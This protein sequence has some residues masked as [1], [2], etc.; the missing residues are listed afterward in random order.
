MMGKMPGR[1]NFNQFIFDEDRH[2][3]T[4]EEQELLL[5]DEADPRQ[6]STPYPHTGST[7]AGALP[8]SDLPVFTTIHQIRRDV[9]ENLDDPY[10]LDQLRAPRMNTTVVRPM[11]DNLYDMLDISVV[12]CLLVNRVQFLREQR[13]QSHHHTLNTTRALLCEL[14]ASR[15]LRRF[16]EDNPGPEGLLKLANILVYG[17]DPFQRCP[18]D[19][20]DEFGNP[21]LRATFGYRGR[22]TALE[23]AIVSNSKM[24]LSSAS[25]QKVMEAIFEGRVVYTPTTF[26]D[27]LPDH[28]KNKK[29]LL[30]NP[31]NAP[32]LNHYRLRVPRTRN[33]LE[34]I[35][36]VVLLALYVGVMEEQDRTRFSMLETAFCVYSFGWILEQLAAMLEHGWKVY[37]QN[38]WAFLDV[39]FSV[40][41]IIYFSLRIDGHNKG[42]EIQIKQA[43]DYLSVGAPVLIP[44]LAFNLLSENM[45]FISLREM[46]A[47]FAILTAL[48][49]WCFLGFFLALGWMS[50]NIY[51]N[52]EISKLM[53]WIWFGLDGTG[54]EQSPKFHPTLGPLL[55]VLFAFLGNTLF[56]TILVSMLSNTFS[57]IVANANAEIQYRRAVM[58]F[59]GVKSDA[60]FS[61]FPPFN[62]PALFLL[63]PLKAC[64]SP[65][66]FHKVIVFT[67]QTINL[68]ILLII[69]LYERQ[70]LW[71]GMQRRPS[72]PYKGRPWFWD[73]SRI[74]AQADTEIVFFAD[75]P[76]DLLPDP[77]QTG[78]LRHPCHDPAPLASPPKRPSPHPHKLIRSSTGQLRKESVVGP[79]GELAEYLHDAL[80]EYGALGANAERLQALEGTVNKMEGQLQR[81]CNALDDAMPD[82]DNNK[83]NGPASRRGS[84]I[85]PSEPPSRRGSTELPFRR[86]SSDVPPSRRASSVAMPDAPSQRG[87]SV[88]PSRRA[89][90]VFAQRMEAV[91]SRRGSSV[92][93]R[94]GS[95]PSRRGGSEVLSRRGSEFNPSPIQE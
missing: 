71:P 16:D 8:Y 5:G 67:V 72:R 32:I 25:C 66:W 54:V 84:A 13:F 77:P 19:V 81:I 88:P 57:S 64:L 59:E 17:F 46:M 65:R 45:L 87:S 74:A 24:L 23:L 18:E 51:T 30:Y 7:F 27:M 20:M 6:G 90:E 93:A 3:A 28:Y 94:R 36:F 56:L 49:V 1:P 79:F 4:E 69:A 89:S 2:T 55:M 52:A 82:D 58:T 86:G 76:A 92:P 34:A 41:F 10:S 75:P 26:I 62:I 29:I 53:L 78:D 12:Y 31:R 50:G 91:A 11:V 42:S 48:A 33:F 68:P 21:A 43:F 61:F 9:I 40:V 70:V 35:Q 47:N 85:G 37:T 39:T 63:L 73:F 83:P 80:E 22:V 95:D 14:I 44:R 38:L 60:I 15:L